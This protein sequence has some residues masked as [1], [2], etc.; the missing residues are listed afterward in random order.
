MNYKAIDASTRYLHRA[1]QQAAAEAN[2]YKYIS[3]A[4]IESSA[5]KTLAKVASMM[6]LT[7]GAIRYRLK[8][9]GIKAR[10]KTTKII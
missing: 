2:G 4:I 6:N 3:E 1:E 7:E 5:S 10:G 9:W 8:Q